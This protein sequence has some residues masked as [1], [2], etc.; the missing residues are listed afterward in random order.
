[1]P[2]YIHVHLH[3]YKMLTEWPYAWCK[4]LS[5]LSL[6]NFSLSLKLFFKKSIFLKSMSYKCPSTCAHVHVWHTHAHAHTQTHTPRA[7]IIC[8]SGED[9]NL[10]QSLLRELS[11]TM[12]N[13]SSVLPWQGR[14]G[15]HLHPLSFCSQKEY[16]PQAI[17][18]HENKKQRLNGSG[19]SDPPRTPQGCY[20]T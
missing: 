7:I 6:C 17:F 13:I 5:I 15:P 9:F 20:R 12:T 1:M 8:F 18:H 16:S 19:K 14:E 10:D 3:T 4:E 11:N 2:H